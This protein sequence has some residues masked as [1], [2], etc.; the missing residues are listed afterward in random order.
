MDVCVACFGH[1]D[2]LYGIGEGGG[3]V[4]DREAEMQGDMDAV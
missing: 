1:Q 4:R 2:F 3:D